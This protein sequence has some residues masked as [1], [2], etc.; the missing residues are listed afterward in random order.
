VP[1]LRRDLQQ[2][3]L[4]LYDDTLKV[5]ALHIGNYQPYTVIDVPSE[6]RYTLEQLLRGLVA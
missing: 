2:Q 6:C 3:L 5:A 4:R 1:T